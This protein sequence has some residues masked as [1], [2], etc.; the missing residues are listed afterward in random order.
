MKKIKTEICHVCN[1]AGKYENGAD[2][3]YGETITW[4]EFC[5]YCDSTGFIEFYEKKCETCKQLCV[6]QKDS[7]QCESCFEKEIKMMMKLN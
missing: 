3:I 7:T 5:E 6:V 4:I 1:G 2:D